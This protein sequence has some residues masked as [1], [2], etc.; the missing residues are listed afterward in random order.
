[1]ELLLELAYVS[2]NLALEHGEA[3]ILSLAYCRHVVEHGH[4][5]GPYAQKGS[6]YLIE[7]VKKV[8]KSLSTFA[9]GTNAFLAFSRGQDAPPK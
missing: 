6:S 7:W 5:N 8:K 1:L 4:A 2:R 3:V 9:A